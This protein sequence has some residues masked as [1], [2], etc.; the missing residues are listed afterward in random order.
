RGGRVGKAKALVGG[1]LRIV[2]I[3][4]IEDGEARGYG[5]ARTFSRGLDDVAAA[6]V[7]HLV[8]PDR[9]RLA[10]VHTDAPAIAADLLARLRSRLPAEPREMTVVAAGP[11]IGVHGGPGAAGVFTVG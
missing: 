11:S 9:A 5:K 7:Q 2:P 1:I 10:V 8:R 6:A 4:Q 3:L